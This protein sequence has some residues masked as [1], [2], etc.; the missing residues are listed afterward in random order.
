[1]IHTDRDNKMDWTDGTNHQ[2]MLELHTATYPEQNYSEHF[3]ANCGVT[4]SM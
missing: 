1:M 2:Q 4:Q 3:H